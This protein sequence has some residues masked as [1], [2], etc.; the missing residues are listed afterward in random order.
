MPPPDPPEVFT[1]VFLQFEIL[2]ERV[3]TKFFF[4]PFLRGVFFFPMCP[5]SKYSE[6]CGEFKNV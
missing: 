4:L 3:G 5:Y 2:G 1:P 6:F